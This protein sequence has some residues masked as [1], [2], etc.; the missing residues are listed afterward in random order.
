MEM[1]RDAL[2]S[3]HECFMAY[4]QT[5]YNFTDQRVVMIEGG[6][7]AMKDF[8]KIIKC[9]ICANLLRNPSACTSCE[10]AF[11][12]RCIKVKFAEQ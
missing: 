7:N 8:E 12:E 10:A 1:P 6:K 11:C 4:S 5:F 3:Q 2:M 9:S